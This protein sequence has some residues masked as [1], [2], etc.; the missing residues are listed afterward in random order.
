MLKGMDNVEN[1]SLSASRENQPTQEYLPD[2]GSRLTKSPRSG[3]LRAHSQRVACGRILKWPTRAD[4]KSAG[5]RLRRFESFSYH[6]DPTVKI[7]RDREHSLADRA[8]TSQHTRDG[9][10]HTTFVARVPIWR[11]GNSQVG[12]PW[13]PPASV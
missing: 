8:R 5:L 9:G 12:F 13:L 6:Q 7:P 4:C 10:S 2:A 3:L 1:D 11:S